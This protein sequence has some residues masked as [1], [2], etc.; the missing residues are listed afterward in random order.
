M[1]EVDASNDLDVG[2]IKRSGTVDSS[3]VAD[4]GADPVGGEVFGV[5]V[6][7]LLPCLEG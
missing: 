3:V 2:F 5:G 1:V 4:A 6:D 7:D